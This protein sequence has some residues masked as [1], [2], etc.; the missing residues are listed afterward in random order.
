MIRRSEMNQRDITTLKRAS[1]IIRALNERL[2]AGSSDWLRE[3]ASSLDGISAS[4]NTLEKMMAKG[5]KGEI[6]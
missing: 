4:S 2:H 6:K 1:E 3:I 5:K